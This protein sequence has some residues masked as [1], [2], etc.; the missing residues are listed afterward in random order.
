VSN[1]K[2]LRG[3]FLGINVASLDKKERR[4]EEE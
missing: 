4:K 1:H 3:L 2:Y